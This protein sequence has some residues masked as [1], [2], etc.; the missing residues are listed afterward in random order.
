M[1][2]SFDSL[3]FDGVAGL[4]LLIVAIWSWWLSRN[5]R[6]GTRVP[7]RFASVLLAALAVSL[8]L[9]APGLAF[10]VALIVSAVASVALALAFRFRPGESVWFSA[11]AL[12]I[13]FGLGLGASLAGA[14]L[15]SFVAVAGTAAYVAVACVS[16]GRRLNNL[17]A[18]LGAMALILGGAA[19]IDDALAP[20]ALFLASTLGLMT[21]G[22][23][24]PIVISDA[25][26]E[27]FVSGERA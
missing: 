1:A 13:S 26:I 7:L 4:V 9:P 15:L 14:P 10:N 11:V 27:L 3:S 24:N 5:L 2:F 8:S 12:A 21:R 23:K 18:L 22:L 16:R 19:M 17:M 20:A 6:A 25:R